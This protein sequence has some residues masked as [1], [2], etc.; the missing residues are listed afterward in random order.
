MELLQF[1]EHNNIQNYESLKNILEI[2]PYNL[3]FKEDKDNINLFLIYISNES[4]L[5]IKLVRECNG[6]IM[7]KNDLKIICYTF[8][9]CIDNNILTSGLNL[10]KLYYENAIE[11]TL[12]RLF[13]HND[14]WILSTKKCI[15]A[16]KA[17]WL[18]TKSFGELF[19]ECL[20]SN[21]YNHPLYECLTLNDNN[22]IKDGVLNKTYCYSFILIH[23][24]NN[25]VI[26]YI[27]PYIYHI[28]TRD[29]NTLKEI[30]INIGFNKLEK[31]FIDYSNIEEIINK[32][33][34]RTI[35]N[36][37]GLIFI[38]ENYNRHKIR[39]PIFNEARD[40]WGNT[41][42]RCLRYLE[43]RKNIDKLNKYFYYFPIDKQLFLYYE[44]T[45]ENL[46][47]AILN[48]YTE[49]HIK[50][51]LIK[52]PYFFSKTIY[53]LHGNF[54]KN[55]TFI[56]FNAVMLCLYELEPKN[57]MYMIHHYNKYIYEQ[58]NNIKNIDITQKNDNLE[59]NILEESIMEI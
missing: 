31:W 43:L 8:D 40:L 6:I 18:T 54:I 20:K 32:L 22:L 3:K 48:I 38:D 16:F 45:I 52:I 14:K 50:K 24:E 30:D 7:R 36:T 4:N 39:T 9:K 59:N 19:C 5:N 2:E 58:N 44:K 13:Y 57:V 49:K 26:K 23:P 21:N 41:N 37:E 46:A 25:V 1:I 55:K 33:N 29:M 11:G 34:E 47:Y 12:I 15:D 27:E 10:N 51:T 56:D 35:C 17:R 53:K 42:N 28:S